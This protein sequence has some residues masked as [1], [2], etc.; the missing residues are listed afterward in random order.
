MASVSTM[1]ETA[2]LTDASSLASSFLSTQPPAVQEALD[3]LAALCRAR[4]SWLTAPRWTRCLSWWDEQTTRQNVQV[5]RA[6]L[7]ARDASE[8]D[9]SLALAHD[10]LSEGK[11]RRSS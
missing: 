2:D 6:V 1:A 11:C 3:E 4:E 5:L 8:L 9:V 10:A 7:T